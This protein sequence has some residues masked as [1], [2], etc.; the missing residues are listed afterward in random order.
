MYYIRV[1]PPDPDRSIF[2]VP[3]IARQMVLMI[4]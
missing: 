2:Q 1:D 3:S 4:Y